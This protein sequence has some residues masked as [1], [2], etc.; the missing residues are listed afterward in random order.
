MHKTKI[1]LRSWLAIAAYT[2]QPPSRPLSV[3]AMTYR[4]HL[5]RAATVHEIQKRVRQA[6]LQNGS[7]AQLLK[8]LVYVAGERH[9]QH[10]FLR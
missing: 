3:R 10:A 4:V 5:S 6:I 1:D 9:D 8:K 2:I 7:E